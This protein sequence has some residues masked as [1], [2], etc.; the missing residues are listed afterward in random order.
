[1]WDIVVK[2][3]PV[4]SNHKYAGI[5]SEPESASNTYPAL[6]TRNCLGDCDMTDAQ[7]YANDAYTDKANKLGTEIWKPVPS[8]PGML[9]SSMGRIVQAP[10]HAPL[11]NGGFRLYTPKPSFG[12]VSRAKKGAAHS[13]RMVMVWRSGESRQ[14]PRKVHQLVCE[15]FHGEKPFDRA[16]VIHLDEDAHNNRPENLKWGTQKE[17]LNMPKVIEG[18]R[19]RARRLSNDD[20]LRIR[21]ARKSGGTLEKIGRNFSISMQSVHDI[22]S[23]KTYSEVR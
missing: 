10:R 22:A 19:Q 1:M 3:V 5:I 6:I 13:Y 23:G 14:T 8:E 20:V 4:L 21:E 18:K 17:N 7:E 16:V 12:V 15:A 2:G 9:A 11:P